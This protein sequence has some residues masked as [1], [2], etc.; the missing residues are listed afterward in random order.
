MLAQHDVTE[1]QWRVLRALNDVRY[2]DATEVS[3]RASILAPSLS[4]I[5]KS[6]ETRGMIRSGRYDKDARRVLLAITPAGVKL[7]QRIFPES[8]AIYEDIDRDWPREGRTASESY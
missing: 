6:L 2:L 5:I 7:I 8:R 1:Q 4:R 3:K